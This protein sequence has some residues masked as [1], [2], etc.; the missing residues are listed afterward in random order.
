[1]VGK[2]IVEFAPEKRIS[3]EF[4]LIWEKFILNTN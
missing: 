1:V 4:Y 2:T 3:K